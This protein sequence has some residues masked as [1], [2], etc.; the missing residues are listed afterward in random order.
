MPS[1]DDTLTRITLHA[2]YFPR[3]RAAWESAVRSAAEQ[4]CFD[5]ELAREF[6]DGNAVVLPSYQVDVPVPADMDSVDVKAAFTRAVDGEVA[7]MLRGTGDFPA[8]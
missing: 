4:A 3:F 1:T 5:I 6:P 2:L 8:A 7:R